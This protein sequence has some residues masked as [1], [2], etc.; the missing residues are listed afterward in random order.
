MKK[1]ILNSILFFYCISINV[2]AQ[3]KQLWGMTGAGIGALKSGSGNIFHYNTDTLN[4]RDDYD[5]PKT[6]L[7]ASPQYT[8]LTYIGNGK[9]YG[10]TQSGGASNNGVIFEWDSATNV[11]TKQFDFDGPVNGSSPY[12]SLTLYNSKLYGL[13]SSGGANGDGVLFVWDPSSNTFTKKIDFDDVAHGKIP[14]GSLTVYNSKLYGMTNS[15]GANAKG[16]IFSYDPALNILTNVHDFT[17]TDGRAPCGSFT[18]VG[19]KL[20][21]MTHNGGSGDAGVIFQFDPA[22]TA[23]TV[24]TDILNS[25]GEY[26]YGDLTFFNNKF[27][28]MTWYDNVNS[29]GVIFEFDTTT[30]TMI[31]K[32]NFTAAGGNQPFGSFTVSG[33]KFYGQMSSG[34]VNN[35]GTLFSYD[36]SLNSFTKLKDFGSSA[37]PGSQSAGTCIAINGTLFGMTGSNGNGTLFKYNI[38]LDSLMNQFYFNDQLN[39][40]HPQGS[41]AYYNGKYYGMTNGAGANYVGVIFE[42]NPITKIY[43]VKH[44]F[45]NTNGGTPFGSLTLLNGKFYGMTNVGGTK[46][47]GVIFQW[48]PIANI[49]VK[50]I[51]FD[52]TTKGA[53]PYGDLKEYNG[54]LY[55]MTNVG[56]LYGYGIIF[57]WDPVLNSFTK[58]IDFDDNNGSAPYGSL[59]LYNNKFYGMTSTGGLNGVGVIFQWDPAS[60]TYNQLYDFAGGG[61]GGN[62]YGTLSLYG[63]NLFGMAHTGGT[64]SLGVIFE[65]NLT[66][67]TYA[68]KISFDG[69][70]KGSDPYGSLTAN[71]G[72]FYGMTYDGGAQNYGALFQ[73]DPATNIFTKKV[74][75]GYLSNNTCIYPGYTTLL[76]SNTM[77]VFKNVPVTQ[78]LCSGTSFNAT[79]FVTD[80]DSDAISLTAI[81]SNLA[82]VP[83]A[84]VTITHVSDTTYHIL[85][86]P[87]TGIT[88][89]TVINVIANDGNGGEINFNLKIKVYASPVIPICLVSVDTSTSTKNVVVWEK[90]VT[91]TIDSFRIYREIGLNNYVRIGSKPYSALSEFTDTTNGV[92]PKIQSYRYKISVFDTCGNE[93]SLSSAHRT[94]H[95]STPQFT[96]PSTFDLIWTNDYEGFSFSQYYI[97]RD[98]NNTGN[99][100]KRDSVTFGN[101]S[102]TDITAPTDSAR[103]IIEAAPLQPC[104]ASFKYPTPNASTVKSSKSNSSDRTNNP[105]SVGEISTDKTISV[106]PNPNHGNFIIRLTDYKSQITKV[107]LYNMMG[108]LIYQKSIINSNTEIQISEIPKGV[109]QLKVI[110]EN[111]STRNKKIIIQ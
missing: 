2:N 105:V 76:S 11:Y 33:N 110:M 70:N 3:H 58:K 30:T 27:Y 13:T 81:S 102:Y 5:F 92:N 72:K 38:A 54:K 10:M 19:A 25:T 71:G 6:H 101:L 37:A 68:R 36:P 1:N 53:N 75:F 16:T 108:E 57:E 24:K 32:Y 56:G 59:L 64:S 20:Y 63:G 95:L 82:L 78:R 85:V 21:A 87:V 22:T 44:D 83:N 69:T 96:A 107:N 86:T 89:S 104:N 106:F 84:S 42:Y 65:Y 34:G 98:G 23:V 15:G 45:D 40:Y 77:P 67:S 47:A 8:H 39:G 29:L 79:F 18:V 91:T 97:L 62:P 26:A 12:G 111:A 74:D 73:W 103:Y 90:P 55:G 49:Y 9:F 7:G 43:T 94:I 88:D 60:N 28:G 4:L 14:Y 48:D 51:D 46:G 50:K 61:A 52:T 66:T 31:K 93:S 99:W 17:G 41:L 35:L 80:A 109:Y 100:I